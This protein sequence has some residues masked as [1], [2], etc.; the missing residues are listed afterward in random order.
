MIKSK[1]FKIPFFILMLVFCLYF[2]G[3]A[4]AGDC[5]EKA[6][7]VGTP[8]VPGEFTIVPDW[9]PPLQYDPANPQTIDR[10]NTITISVIGGNP[11]YTWSV[12]G[13]GFTLANTT[14]TGLSNTLTA[15]ATA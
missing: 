5:A 6:G 2:S 4:L 9:H 14:T 13:T 3:I 8:T 11:P 15:D 1:F 10:N 7:G 12:S